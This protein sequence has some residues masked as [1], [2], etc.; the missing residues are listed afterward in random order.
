M[1]WIT[2]SRG[3]FEAMEKKNIR[4]ISQ[5]PEVFRPCAGS[6]N[7]WI[8]DQT[9]DRLDALRTY[10]AEPVELIIRRI[11]GARSTDA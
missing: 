11:L 3:L 1:P 7:I 9:A 8:A 5:D 6:V 4:P 10:E 2:V